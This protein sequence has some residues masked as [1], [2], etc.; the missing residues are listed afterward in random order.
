MPTPLKYDLKTMADGITT[1]AEI[2]H[3]NPTERSKV[4]STSADDINHGDTVT[5]EQ[6]NVDTLDRSTLTVYRHLGGWCH[7][8]YER[9]R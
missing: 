9:L 8:Q 6:Q 3:C 4:T 5:G 1:A 7:I 2:T